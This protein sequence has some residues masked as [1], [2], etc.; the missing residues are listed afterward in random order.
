MINCI[1]S[2]LRVNFEDCG[3]RN[4]ILV[5]SMVISPHT[6]SVYVYIK[7]MLDWCFTCRILMSVVY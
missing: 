4:L 1:I 2:A 7:A 3:M 5:F 6:K